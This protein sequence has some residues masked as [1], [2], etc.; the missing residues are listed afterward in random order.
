[1]RRLVLALAVLALWPGTAHAA[2][3]CY[4]AA[5]RD[6]AHPCANARLRYRVDPKPS[7]AAHEHGAPCTRQKADGLAQPCAF[8]AP[9]GRARRTFA[10]IG[11]SH[12]AH[13]RTA[14]AAVAKA[15]RWRGFALTRNSCP[16]SSA[17]RPLPEPYASQCERFKHDVAHWLAHH[18]AVH[19]VFVAQEVSDVAPVPFAAAAQSYVDEWRTLPA[20]VRRVVVIRDTP[21]TRPDVLRCVSR[22]A[23]RHQ[24]PDTACEQ[25]LI[26][27]LAPDPAVAAARQ[28]DS[29]RFQSVDLTGFFC[30]RAD[31]F[32]VVG[33][34]LVYLDQNHLT[35][36]FVSTLAPY[37]RRAVDRL[38]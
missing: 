8:G 14:L 1:V 3:R 7:L 11:D 38:K 17:G 25:P 27:A 28:E 15:K 26:V 9:A 22:A 30:D 23:A 18:P 16:F 6:A 29:V 37:L 32:P 21:T 24:R 5:S 19:T 13:W 2:P 31:C 33:G 35:P 4:G 36:L 10:L 12:A 34:V 20:S